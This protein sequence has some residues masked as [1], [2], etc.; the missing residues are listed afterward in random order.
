MWC[1]MLFDSDLLTEQ[2]K[3]MKHIFFEKTGYGEYDLLSVN[4]TT[5]TFL[6]KNGGTYRLDEHQ[7]VQWIKGPAVLLEDRLI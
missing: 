4:F 3:F 2:Q 1:P 6:T 7:E 5:R